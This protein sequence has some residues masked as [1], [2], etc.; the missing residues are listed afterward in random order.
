MHVHP[1]TKQPTSIH[2][3]LVHIMYTHI[4]C[5]FY[6]NA[7]WSL[8]FSGPR[9]TTANFYH[10]HNDQNYDDDKGQNYDT[11]YSVIRFL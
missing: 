6:I 5:P 8:D 3:T 7:F 11:Y 4:G 10:H 9:I 1:H 2:L